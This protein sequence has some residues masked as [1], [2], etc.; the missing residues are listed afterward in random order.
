M[1][2]G[3]QTLQNSVIASHCLF[4]FSCNAHLLAARHSLKPKPTQQRCFLL[5]WLPVLDAVRKCQD[6]LITPG[7]PSSLS[8]TSRQYEQNTC[9]KSVVL[10]L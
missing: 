5:Q 9:L 8:A 10:S 4:L 3:S 2:P 6:I 1:N 7:T